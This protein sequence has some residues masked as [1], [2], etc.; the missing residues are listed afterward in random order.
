MN[1]VKPRKHPFVTECLKAGKDK[2]TVWPSSGEDIEKFKASVLKITKDPRVIKV[3][4]ND[5]KYIFTLKK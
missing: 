5:D 4:Q 2:L 3:D 1:E